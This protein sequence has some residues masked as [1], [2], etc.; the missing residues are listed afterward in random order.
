MKELLLKRK[1]KFVQYLIATFMF[2]ITHFAQMIVFALIF[3][4]IEKADL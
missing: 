2:I 3:G 1:A 4:A